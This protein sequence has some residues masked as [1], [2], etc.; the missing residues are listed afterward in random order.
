MLGTVGYDFAL[1]IRMIKILIKAFCVLM[2]ILKVSTECIHSSCALSTQ[3]SEFRVMAWVELMLE[4]VC[5]V[6]IQM[7]RL[8]CLTVSIRMM[9]LGHME[10]MCVL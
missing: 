7:K 8:F 9:S 2:L 5:H 6:R 10:P 3:L 1:S 4:H